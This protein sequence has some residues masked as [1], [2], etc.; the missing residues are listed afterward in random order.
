MKSRWTK[1]NPIRLAKAE[2]H[3]QRQEGHAA[4]VAS[5]QSRPTADNNNPQRQAEMSPAERAQQYVNALESIYPDNG[6]RNEQFHGRTTIASQA[7]KPVHAHTM[8]HALALARDLT[9][10]LHEEL[11]ETA[12]RK[13]AEAGYAD[14]HDAALTLAAMD[15]LLSSGAAE[16]CV[17]AG[18]MPLGVIDRRRPQEPEPE[19]TARTMARCRSTLIQAAH[20]GLMVT[21]ESVRTYANQAGFIIAIA[22]NE[23]RAEGEN[24]HNGG[25]QA[26]AAVSQA[27]ADVLTPAVRTLRK[28]HWELRRQLGED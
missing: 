20:N 2:P 28:K 12:R 3:H 21:L 25:S 11:Q 15:R 24:W 17:E 22:H 18:A 6:V 7:A 19:D 9:D 10:A 26:A 16:A 4:H 27:A 13:L 23:S 1:D 8:N 14:D 5:G